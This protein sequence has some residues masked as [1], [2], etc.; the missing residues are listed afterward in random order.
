MSGRFGK[1]YGSSPAHLLLGGAS[2]LLAA[3]AIWQLSALPTLLNVL[4]WLFGSVVLH[5]FVALPIYAGIGRGGIAVTRWSAGL[6]PG[7]REMA[8]I[9]VFNHIRVPAIVS[10]ILLLLFFPLILSIPEASFRA[11]TGLTTNVYLGRWLGI[12]AVLFVGSGLLLLIRVQRARR[13]GTSPAPSGSG[14]DDPSV[15]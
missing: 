6:Y 8:A 2:F 9:D 13:R 4:I 1:E 5:D 15:N 11:T 14:V 12:V 7:D 10:G 3:F